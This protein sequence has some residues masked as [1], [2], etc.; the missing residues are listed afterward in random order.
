MMKDI[1]AL[2]RC[3]MSV[4]RIP[5]LRLGHVLADQVRPVAQMSII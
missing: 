1:D 3:A 5:C 2:G 4:L